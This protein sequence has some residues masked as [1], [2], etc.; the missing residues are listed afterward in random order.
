MRQFGLTISLRYKSADGKSFVS[1]VFN[2]TINVVEPDERMDGE[3][4]FLYI[5]LGA[6]VILLLI[7]GNHLRT[8]FMKK[9]RTGKFS[10]QRVQQNGSNDSSIPNG[11]DYRWIPKEHLQQRKTFD[12][13]PKMISVM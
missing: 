1:H 5:L 12:R 13:V 7:G 8:T 4:F 2:D 3:M 6:I 10:P 9:T 11:I